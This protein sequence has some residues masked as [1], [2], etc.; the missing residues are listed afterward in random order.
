MSKALLALLAMALCGAAPIRAAQPDAGTN[1]VAWLHKIAEAAHEQN[2]AGTYIHQHGNRIDTF[3]IVHLYDDR[4]E[5][6]KLEVLDD[7]SREIVRN[8][9]EVLCFEGDAHSVVIEKRKFRNT[10]PALLPSQMETLL[11]NYE[12]K[13][14]EAG[15]VTGIPCQN[16]VLEPKDN[17]RY[18]HKL[19]ATASGMLLRSSTLNS[20]NEVVAQTAFTQITIGGQIDKM[21]LKPK[22]SGRKLVLNSKPVEAEEGSAAWNVS[23]LPPGFTKTM[24]IKRKLPGKDSPVNHLV[25]SD[26]LATLSVFIEPLAGIAK[27]MQGLSHHGAT[28]IYAKTVD[29]HQVTVLGE[30]P[31]VTVMQMGNS[32]VHLK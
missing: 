20:Q 32:V 8:N 25:F 2:Y 9:G 30:V 31:A 24:A 27:P 13:M 19:C 17:L 6:E 7:V 4:G 18:R 15:R 26:G 12:A 16:I 29:N 11:E 5:H 28:H 3:K 22:L 23:P 21:Q 10:F 1:A 14:G